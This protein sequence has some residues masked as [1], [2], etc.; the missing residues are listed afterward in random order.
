M[1]D[2]DDTM[3]GWSS[4]RLLGEELSLHELAQISE[5]RIRVAAYDVALLYRRLNGRGAAEHRVQL[6]L[7][8]ESLKVAATALAGGLTAGFKEISDRAIDEL[9][10]QPKEVRK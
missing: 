2:D 8:H 1:A 5:T 7:A 4:E 10:E 9:P 3:P 6:R